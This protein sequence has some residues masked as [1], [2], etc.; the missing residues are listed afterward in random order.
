[1]IPGQSIYA[2]LTE[3]AN[4][5][6]A[7]AALTPSELTAVAEYISGLDP[8]GGIPSQ[9]FGHVSAHLA[10]VRRAPRAASAKRKS[11]TR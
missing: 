7:V 10:G 3:A 5:D 9:I 4:L 2:R 8:Q 11:P 6:E 1:M